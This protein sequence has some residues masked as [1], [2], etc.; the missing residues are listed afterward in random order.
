MRHVQ[1]QRNCLLRT[2][3]SPAKNQKVKRYKA[4]TPELEKGHL[5]DYKSSPL[6]LNG[7]NLQP[8]RLHFLV[9]GSEPYILFW[10]IAGEGGFLKRQ[11]KCPRTCLNKAHLT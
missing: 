9:Q 4:P 10:S 5:G 11:L 6:S 2:P 3:P 7:D 1:G 8:P